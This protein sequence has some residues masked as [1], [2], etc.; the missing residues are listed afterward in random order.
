MPA[1]TNPRDLVRLEIGDTTAD[2]L[3]TDDEIAVY[4]ANRQEVY[5]SGGTVTNITLAAA[6]LCDVLATRFARGF[7]FSEDGQSFDP[8]E[9]SG[10]YAAR[11]KDLRARSGSGSAPL[12]SPTSTAVGDNLYSF[13]GTIR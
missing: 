4:V 12:V 11:A 8:G 10:F 1:I 3:F 9:R 6:D 7:K 13:G 5:S 2:A